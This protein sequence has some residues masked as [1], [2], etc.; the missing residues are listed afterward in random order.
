MKWTLGLC[1]ALC[2]TPARAQVAQCWDGKAV[3]ACSDTQK[4]TVVQT[5]AYLEK[6][7][8]EMERELQGKTAELQAAVAADELARA[9]CATK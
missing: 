7:F 8:R 5:V 2:V 4:T 6:R 9:A 3:V 1:L